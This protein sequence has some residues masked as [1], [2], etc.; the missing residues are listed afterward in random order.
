MID[1]AII[2]FFAVLAMTVAYGIMI[3]CTQVDKDG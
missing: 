2:L 1:W 3:I